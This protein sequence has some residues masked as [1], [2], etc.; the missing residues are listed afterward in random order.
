MTKFLII[1]GNSI[2]CRA[3]FAGPKTG[4]DLKTTTGIETGTIV[5]FFN[6]INKV[7]LQLEP[8]HI[9]CCWDTDAHTFRK[10]LYP[11]YKANRHNRQS[12]IDMSTVHRQFAM[13]RKMLDILGIK[14]VNVQ[15][16]EGD[17]LV[18]SFL[19]IS[20]AD[21]N[22]ICSG[23][24]DSWALVNDNTTAVFPKSGFTDVILATPEYIEDKFM[25]KRA[26]YV[27]LK[28][29]QGDVS[30]N[31][32]GLEGCGPKTAAKL[33]NEFNDI[34]TIA[35]LT[36][37]DL[38]GYNKK[39]RNNFA[40]WKQRFPI[41]KELMTIRT[42]VQLPY[43][44]DDCEIDL[45]NWDEFKIYIKGLEMYNFIQRIEWGAVYRLKY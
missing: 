45:L 19:A 43:T 2:G 20:N 30:D 25:I 23:D 21:M 12:N 17:D 41:L 35:A 4:D 36:D 9:V 44:F 31:V 26:N 27:G 22:Y 3:A 39:I 24:K 16:F 14:S 18:G 32:K 34:D 42:D 6:I 10:D 8:T 13:I 28:M 7:M 40:D 33:L 37:E 29:L 38:A 11:E 15:K 5:R 1:D